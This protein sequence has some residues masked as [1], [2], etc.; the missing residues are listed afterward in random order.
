[1]PDA[2]FLPG[3]ELSRLLYE[4]AVRP[5]LD[6][7]F[8]GLRYAAARVGEGSEVLGFDSE[9]SADH[10]WGTRLDLFV[11]P[12]AL[13]L[14]AADIRSVLAERLPKEIRGWPTSFRRSDDPDDPVSH[15]ELVEGAGRPP[16][17]PHPRAATGRGDRRRRVP[18]RRR[19]PDR[20]PPA[21]RV[22][23]GRGL[24]IPARAP[25]GQHLAGGGLR[26]PLRGGR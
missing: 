26:G 4:E 24:A 19:R 2:R 9:R 8:P 17:A 10:E 20:R 13:E 12:E 6:E 3:L 1:M 16:L 15:M 7:A 25:V 21:A 14:H 5:I 18:R 23:S 11:E 22:V